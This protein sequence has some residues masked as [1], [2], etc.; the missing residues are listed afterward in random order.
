MLLLLLL[1]LLLLVFAAGYLFSNNRDKNV[2]HLGI[3]VTIRAVWGMHLIEFLPQQFNPAAF[4]CILHSFMP[5]YIIVM[6]TYRARMSGGEMSETLRRVE[7]D[8]A[9]PRHRHNNK[10]I[11]F[12][13]QKSWTIGTS[14]RHQSRGEILPTHIP[15]YIHRRCSPT[16]VSTRSKPIVDPGVLRN[17]RVKRT[18]QTGWYVR[19]R[20]RQHVALES[21]GSS[22][23]HSDH[24]GQS[25]R[26]RPIRRAPQEPRTSYGCPKPVRPPLSNHLTIGAREHPRHEGARSLGGTTKTRLRPSSKHPISQPAPLTLKLRGVPEP[27]RLT[28]DTHTVLR[29]LPVRPATGTSSPLP[30]LHLLGRLKTNKREGWR[31]FGITDGESIADHMYRMSIITLLCPPALAARLDLGRCTRMALVHD[32]AE[33]LVGDITPVDGVPKAEKSRREAATMDYLC[34]GLLGGVGGG[35]AADAAAGGASTTTDADE[36]GD[37]RGGP[38]RAIRALWQEYEDSRTLEAKFVHD[39]DKLELLLQMLEYERARAGRVDLSEFGWVAAR[40]ELPEVR[41]WADELLA[42]RAVFWEGL[43]KDGEEEAGG[44]VGGGGGGGG[45]GGSSR[46]R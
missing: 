38:G 8:T 19:G 13:D 44:V 32:M 46:Q 14:Q 10:H 36:D 11:E 22:V 12:V 4:Q 26:R 5:I 28:T 27:A 9:T 23:Y 3:F 18:N 45:G 40:I 1:L 24:D 43:R 2:A 15:R 33:S 34:G 39:V 6:V 30:F 41:A 31:R 7:L 42:D 29:T 17:G 21:V 16:A 20:R 25:K 37:Q 35:I